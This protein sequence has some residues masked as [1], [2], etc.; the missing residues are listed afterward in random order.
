MKSVLI[1]IQPKW[2]EKIARGEKTIEVRKTRPKIETPFKCYIYCTDGQLLYADYPNGAEN[3]V[4]KLGD[5]KVSGKNKIGNMLNGKV[6]GEFTCDR[7]VPFDVPYPAWSKEYLNSIFNGACLTYGELHA[8]IGSGGRGYGWH[9]TDLK[10]YDKPRELS[11]FYSA[12]WN[13]PCEHKKR[14]FNMDFCM[15]YENGS[16]F[17]KELNCDKKRL[18]RPPQSYMFVESLGE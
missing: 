8:Y 5:Y 2:V 4:I 18:T 6:V 11:E 10:I 3:K 13:M 7:I 17:C 12:K 9:I 14:G 15:A 1:S 16:H